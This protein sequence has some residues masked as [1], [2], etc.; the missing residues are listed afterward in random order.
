[1]LFWVGKLLIEQFVFENKYYPF[2]FKITATDGLGTLKNIKYSDTNND[3]QLIPKSGT[4]TL[5]NHLFNCLDE[6]GLNSQFSTSDSFL[7]T[8][9]K[10]TESR[11][12]LSTNEDALQ[13][14]R[15]NHKAFY[16]VNEKGEYKFESCYTVLE[17]ICQIFRAR[18]F[19]ANGSF[20]FIGL[21]Q[22]EQPTQIKELY[23]EQ[24]RNFRQTSTLSRVVNVDQDDIKLGSGSFRYLQ[25]VKNVKNTYKHRGSE[26]LLPGINWS[27]SNQASYNIGRIVKNG[28]D[29]ILI[30]CQIEW[31]STNLVPNKP[32]FHHWRFTIR[33]GNYYLHRPASIDRYNVY[34]SQ[35]EWRFNDPNYY[36]VATDYFITD[37]N[38]LGGVLNINFK[39]PIM[40]ETGDFIIQLEEV[41]TFDFLGSKLSSPNLI[42]DWNTYNNSVEYLKGGKTAEREESREYEITSDT[43]IGNTTNIHIKTLIGDGVT[44]LSLGKLQTSDN[45]E[46][47]DSS[48]WSTEGENE[49]LFIQKLTI[50]EILNHRNKPLLLMDNPFRSSTLSALYVINYDSQFWV[51]LSGKFASYQDNWSGT[52]FSVKK[53]SGGIFRPVK[54][55]PPKTPVVE[56][57]KKEE[58][59]TSDRNIP[60]S[61]L[62]LIKKIKNDVII[63]KG[64]TVTSISVNALPAGV[65]LYKDD[66]ITVVNPNTGV[67]Q[68]IKLTDNLDNPSDSAKYGE[69]STTLYVEA[70]TPTVDFPTDSFLV[71]DDAA[72]PIR[73]EESIFKSLG[74]SGSY[75]DV[76]FDLPANQVDERLHVQRDIYVMIY[77]VHYSI[78][79]NMSGQR[80]RINWLVADLENENILIKLKI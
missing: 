46:Y 53:N 60:I 31:N 18:L 3:S 54:V 77:D 17:Q 19:F 23:Y 29:K 35:A 20:R 66:I 48:S 27:K 65:R 45:T 76:D 72:S 28:E 30:R 51:M 73:V 58:T 25:A 40:P 44:S 37:I 36:E 13:K 47:A 10:W 9:M 49:N 70:F 4:D 2:E 38:E 61:I 7:V 64:A 74:Q 56:G 41:G 52:W 6:I 43:E 67:T 63:N 14:T 12:N 21:D 50:K 33:L 71:K 42:L 39:T 34:F 32:Y 1:V 24:N 79:T 22:Y 11:H 5:F 78:T 59:D 80:R 8:S 57:G 15:V 75:T 62:E 68:K 69:G 55:L 26:N 16:A